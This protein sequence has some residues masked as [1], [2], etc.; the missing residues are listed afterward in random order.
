MT[1]PEYWLLPDHQHGRARGHLMGKQFGGSGDNLRNL[2]SLHGWANSPVMSGIETKI[3]TEIKS[4]RQ[5]VSY[6]TRAVYAPGS[7]TP[8]A[9]HLEAHGTGGMNVDCLVLNV[10][11]EDNE[12]ICSSQTY[13]G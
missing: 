13:G 2:V 11:D 7:G 6:D 5:R 9:I 10:A 4:G 12:P 8:L 3:K 1:P